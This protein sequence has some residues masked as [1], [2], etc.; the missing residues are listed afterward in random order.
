MNVLWSSKFKRNYK[1]LP[2]P[3]RKK[4]QK[5]LTLL[6]DNVKHPS[7]RVKKME[8]REDVWE[9]R[10]DKFYRFTF[11]KEEE[12]LILRTVGPHDEALRS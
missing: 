10:V 8:S 3:I 5:Q 7:L 11:Q 4:F 12:N 1:K 2:E 9:A 6:L